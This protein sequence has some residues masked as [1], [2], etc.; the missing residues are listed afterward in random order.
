MRRS[1]APVNRDTHFRPIL[2][3]ADDTPPQTN[4]A[5]STAPVVPI[6]QNVPEGNLIDLSDQHAQGGNPATTIPQGTQHT[7]NGDSNTQ[8]V[9]QQPSE[10]TLEQ[11][12]L[13]VL[14]EFFH[15]RE[16]S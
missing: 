3:R 4:N 14:D 7:T 13:A 16:V 2:G 8:P 15:R 5:N 10:A 6:Q 12:E 11:I 9:P 1:R